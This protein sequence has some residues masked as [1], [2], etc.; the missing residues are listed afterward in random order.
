MAP[1]SQSP[2]SVG[3][4]AT[5]FLATGVA[6]LRLPTVKTYP[7]YSQVT[8]VAVPNG[9]TSTIK[10][11]GSFDD[12]DS[13]EKACINMND[14][15]CW[16]YTYYHDDG[17]NFTFAAQCFGLTAPRFSPTPEN[18][19][20]TGVVAWNCRD[21]SD[22]SFN[23][24]CSS[25]GVCECNAAWSGNRCE[26]LNLLPD[27]RNSGYRGVDDGKNTS[28]W[29]GAVLKGEDG[30]Y[31]MWAAEMTEHCGIGAWAQNSRIIRATSKTPGGAYER[32]QVVFDVFSHEP[33]VVQGPNGEYVM[34]YTAQIRSEHGDCNCCQEGVSKCDGSTGPNDCPSK[35]TLRDNDPSYMAYALKPEGPWSSP[36][37]LW[38]EYEG[39]DT[40]FAPVILPNGTIVAIWRTWE[41]VRGSRCYLAIGE[42]W[43]DTSTYQQFEV[44]LFPDLGAAGTEDPFLYIDAKGRFHAVFHHMYGTDTLDHWWLLAEG[45]HAFSEDGI[46][47]TYTGV[48]WGDPLDRKRG[49]VVTYKDGSTFRFTRRERPHLILDEH[50]NPTH[51][52]TAAQYG[53]GKIPTEVGDNG[54]ASYTMIQEIA[55]Q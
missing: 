15:R 22:C 17:S 20:F 52:I 13:C 3:G 29:G 2:I 45:G 55:H 50:G 23:G 11:L 10:Y 44:E 25:D 18:N 30:L 46:N 14:E 27:E 4:M 28:S 26:M 24:V 53:T 42:N 19:S 35:H 47:W 31:H 1:M 7:G 9:N 43:N 34:F 32:D 36:Q 33:E 54:D 6:A 49:N 39:A 51:L 5:L 41:S 40:N 38:P 37:Q 21:D 12:A 16:S 48:A 8:N